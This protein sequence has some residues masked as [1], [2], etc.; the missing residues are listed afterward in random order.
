MGK[1]P[2][3][4]KV[5]EVRNK[6]QLS[7]VLRTVECQRDY[8]F[9]NKVF[10]NDYTIPPEDDQ[11]K[12]D[13]TWHPN[14]VKLYCRNGMINGW[15]DINTKL[16]NNRFIKYKLMNQGLRLSKYLLKQK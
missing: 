2:I 1:S 15:D 9:L 16:D 12:W 11:D 10:E 14:G 4:V 8:S 3:I 5:Y 7:I 6:K 13:F